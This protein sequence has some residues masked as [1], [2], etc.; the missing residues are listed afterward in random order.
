MKK[1]NVTS[2]YVAL[3][4][5]ISDFGKIMKDMK[6]IRNWNNMAYIEAKEGYSHANY[7]LAPVIPHEH[8]DGLVQK[9]IDQEDLAKSGYKLHMKN[10]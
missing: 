9:L 1:I 3:Q 2:I 5:D 6:H 4:I 8:R 7:S 10:K